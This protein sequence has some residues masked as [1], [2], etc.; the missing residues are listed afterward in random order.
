MFRMELLQLATHGDLLLQEV[1]NLA[2]ENGNAL[3][4][5]LPQALVLCVA[6]FAVQVLHVIF[7][8]GAKHE[9]VTILALKLAV[10]THAQLAS[11]HRMDE[12]VVDV[13][14]RHEPIQDSQKLRPSVWAA[15]RL[16]LRPVDFHWIL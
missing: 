3:L 10:L 4:V 5:D 13:N 6:I 9:V 15:D 2:L 8:H 1:L 14:E 12:R 11:G 7:V 16:E